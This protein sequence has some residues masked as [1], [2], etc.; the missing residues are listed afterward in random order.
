M[1]TTVAVRFVFFFFSCLFR[2]DGGRVLTWAKR[3]RFRVVFD[4][5][6]SGPAAARVESAMT[7]TERRM[8]ILG[9]VLR[10]R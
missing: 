3:P 2:A 10:M 5:G 7:T 6:G 4:M 1:P 8:M 9:G